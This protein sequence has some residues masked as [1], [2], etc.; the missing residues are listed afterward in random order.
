V[1]GLIFSAALAL[2]VL[3]PCPV[4]AE[5]PAAGGDEV[6][7][8][9][10]GL[11]PEETFMARLTGLFEREDPTSIYSFGIGDKEV[12]FI[13]DG[14]WDVKLE[15]VLDIS[16]E[17]STPVIAVTPPVFSQSVDLSSWIVN[18]Q[19]LVFRV[20]LRGGIHPE[21]GC[22]RLHGTGGFTCPPC[23]A[24]QRRDTLSR[25]VSLH[26]G[27]RRP[28]DRPRCHGQ[29]RGGQVAG[30]RRRPLRRLEGQGDGA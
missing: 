12:G 24:R 2:C 4:S 1:K 11:D 14:S 8:V 20:I 21:H 6:P 5:T 3:L 7:V 29:L 28:D 18:Q 30:R 23:T 27:R 16:F 22:R 19:H 13:L 9:P 25:P 10:P 26:Q 15:S 17:G